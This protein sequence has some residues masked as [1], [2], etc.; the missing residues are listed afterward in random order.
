MY[1]LEGHKGTEIDE[2]KPLYN[3]SETRNIVNTELEDFLTES[4]YTSK[5]L[6][7]VVLG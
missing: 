6:D 1:G 7:D 2:S 5:N 3:R 4:E